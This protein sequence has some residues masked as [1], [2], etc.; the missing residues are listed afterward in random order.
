MQDVI[1]GVAGS[2]ESCDALVMVM[3][4]P[5]RRGIELELD[6]PSMDAF[7][8]NMERAVRETLKSLGIDHGFVKVQDRGAL[9][10]T[11]RARTET[12]TR[13]ALAM[14]ID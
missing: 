2:L 9:D 11:L 5:E 7:G 8:E 3:L 6:S 10:C 14:I 4:S 1:T 13:R 12:A